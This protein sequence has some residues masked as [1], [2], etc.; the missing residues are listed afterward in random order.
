MRISVAMAVY[1]GET[2]IRKQLESIRK[3]TKAVNEVIISDDRSTDRTVAIIRQFIARHDLQDRWKVFVNEKNLGYA[4]NFMNAVK[5]TENELIMF[6][7]QDDIWT[8]DRVAQMEKIM[9]KYPQI[10]LLGSEFEPFRCVKD[11]VKPQKWELRQMRN[12]NSLEQ[13]LFKPKN[14]F[15]GCQGCTMCFRRTFFEKIE[16]YWVQGWAH[17]DFV[18]K[19]ALCLDGLFVYHRT[20][21]K[22]RLHAGNA[23]L[24]RMHEITKRIAF[25]ET[26]NQSYER[27]LQFAKD[28]HLNQ[29]KIHMLERDIVATKL[30]IELLRDRRYCNVFPL[31]MSY[32]NCFHRSRAILTE[33]YLA[34]DGG[35]KGKRKIAA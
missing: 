28:V 22:R 20:T 5:K 8:S 25:L 13:L 7:D 12:D 24:Q 1:N 2:Y 27:T 30:R 9:Q 29:K 35:R 19:L 26:L 10:M 21:V 23:S 18:W 31:A 3:Q 33:L 11:A 6:C 16:T 4:A 14:I 17:D 15:I 32:L 34:V